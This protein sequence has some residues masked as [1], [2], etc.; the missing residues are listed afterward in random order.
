[1]NHWPV[2]NKPSIA[3]FLSLSKES[4]VKLDNL[5]DRIVWTFKHPEPKPRPV[6]V[7]LS[8][9]A[10]AS[11]TLFSKDIKFASGTANEKRKLARV[12]RFALLSVARS[13]LKP[14]AVGACVRVPLGRPELMAKVHE[15]GGREE[16]RAHIKNLVTC[17][18]VWVCPVCSQKISR[19]RQAELAKA[20]RSFDGT[21]FMAT[22]TLQHKLED[23]LNE[24]NSDL[25]DVLR[26]LISGGWGE[27]FESKWG[28]IGNIRKYED[29]W[30][31]KNGHHP[32]THFLFWSIL[33]VDQLDQAQ[34]QLELLGR[35]EKLMIKHGRYASAQY[36]VRV[37]KGLGTLKD[38]DEALKLY[39]AKWGL[40]AEMTLGGSKRGKS[41][42]DGSHY[43]PWELLELAGLG[44]NLAA[45]K[46]IEYVRATKGM[47]QLRWSPGLRS[48]LGLP[49]REK[50]DK[51]LAKEEF[52]PN[53]YI[54]AQL[55]Y[56]DWH[57][58]IGNDAIAELLNVA[59]SGSPAMITD[60]IN[61]LRR[62]DNL[63]PLRN[64]YAVY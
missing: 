28:L 7:D 62:P 20:M 3:D 5:A 56:L 21:V 37:E 1:M 23:P 60:F 13:L 2:M 54:L 40:S 12:Y 36:G 58:V 16:I 42:A 15:I 22:F 25:K 61:G 6:Q 27:R 35:Y 49:S 46:W 50:S 39:V 44:D 17:G 30:S 26:H 48:R 38:G 24:L 14:H 53:D 34:I 41:A 33:P 57:V 63:I 4:K 43:T 51:E 11:L 18:N 8:A 9:R 45:E 10:R 47:R 52:S 19:R 64:V 31:I 29:N 59:D 55:D 32:H